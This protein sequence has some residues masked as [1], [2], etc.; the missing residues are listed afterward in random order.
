MAEISKH[1]T[2]Y[3]RDLYTS[4]LPA[5]NPG[6]RPLRK[7]DDDEDVS[8][9]ILPSEVR[10]AIMEL[11]NGK[12]PGEDGILNEF[13]KLGIEE[14]I[15]PITRLFNL[16]LDT[17]EVPKQW[18]FSTIILLHKKGPKDD[19]NNYRPISLM[20]NLYKLFSQIITKR[21]TKILDENQPPEQAGFR[22]GYST[23]DHIQTVNQIFEKM[24]E[25]NHEIHI[26]FID[27][28]K[29]FDSVEH[30]CVLQAL[31]NQGMQ[32]KY[33][34]LLASI[35]RNS[36]AKV[37]TELEGSTFRIERGVKQ[38]DPLSP[39]LF[40]CLLEN[41]FRKIDWDNKYGISINGRR[42]TNL[43]FADDIVL[44]AKTGR[45][46]ENMIHDVN[47]QQRSRSFNES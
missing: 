26:A 6:R 34:R 10:T 3:Y 19:L 23:T 5:E 22:S 29:A 17:E 30:E 43:R 14:I 35:Y 9:S 12:I 28:T 4:T 40:T 37:R 15:P 2:D 1:A 32:S 41:Q 36:Y 21:L 31:E 7:K 16:I 44:F 45:E 33:V 18:N 8:L 13:I 27:Y 42:L 25:Y 39:K 46:L 11:K 20:S 38:G 24:E 47:S